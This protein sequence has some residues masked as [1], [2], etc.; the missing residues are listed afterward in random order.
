MTL[1]TQAHLL[2]DLELLINTGLGVAPIAPGL[3]AL[4]C[5]I[6]GAEAGGLSWFSETGVHEGFYQR[7]S[8]REAELLFMNR[9][10]ELFAGPNEYKPFLNLS[11][12]RQGIIHAGPASRP[13]LHSNTFNLFIKPSR[14]HF[15]LC[16]LVDL[17]GVPRLAGCFFKIVANPFYD[18]DA[19]KLAMLIPLLRCAIGTCQRADN[20]HCSARTRAHAGFGRRHAG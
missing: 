2:K 5:K 3:S 1:K 18:S 13:Y 15:L 17:E 20:K 7:G 6:V 12:K 9:Y 19:Q 16:V 8:T 14:C 4:L 11:N 10:K